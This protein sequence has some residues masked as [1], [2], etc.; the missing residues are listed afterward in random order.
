MTLPYFS[1]LAITPTDD[2]EKIIKI[3]PE[4]DKV[5]DI[6]GLKQRIEAAIKCLGL[7]D[8]W[9]LPLHQAGKD[10]GRITS[11]DN[12]FIAAYEKAELYRHD[13]ILAYAKEQHLPQYASL[14]HNFI[15]LAPVECGWIREMQE[16]YALN[17][18]YGYYDYYIV[19]IEGED[20]ENE[21]IFG[22]TCRDTNSPDFK[23]HMRGKEAMVQVLAE[24]IHQTSRR[25]IKAYAQ[26]QKMEIPVITPKPLQLLASLANQDLS[27]VQLAEKLCISYIT[28]HQQI[29][30]ARKAFGTRT[31]IGAI[32][33]A[34]KLGMIEFTE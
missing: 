22:V 14:L 28:A 31:S 19:I 21:A 16:N 34:I 10:M 26:K 5:R 30:A 32:K 7:S 12:A 18:A 15:Q 20:G 25:Y 13:L 27:L 3:Y 6:K 11:L 9:Y 1:P 8:Y 23:A 2:P 33:K 24:V 17:A 29:N 4:W